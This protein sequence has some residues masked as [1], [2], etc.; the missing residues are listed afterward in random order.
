MKIRRMKAGD[1]SY[2]LVDTGTG[3]IIA[4]AAQT[5]ERGRDDYPWEWSLSNDMIFGKLSARTGHSVETLREA[6]DIVETGANQYGLLK[7]VGPVDPFDIK[8]NQ[9]FRVMQGGR[10]N[11]YR[12][13]QSAYGTGWNIEI[14]ANHS[15]GELTEVHLTRDQHVTLYEPI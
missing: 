9:V 3:E 8:E 6:I 5:G 1:R 13:T 2:Y 10:F 11:Y 7:P 4:T 14:P 12:S 15:S